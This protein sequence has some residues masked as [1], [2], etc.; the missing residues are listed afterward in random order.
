[1]QH[2]HTNWLTQLSVVNEY[3]P[4][5]LTGIWLG[6]LVGRMVT[7]RE[8][9]IADKQAGRTVLWKPGQASAE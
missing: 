8:L 7:C 9:Y 3:R 4:V 6:G 5:P 1:M 2:R